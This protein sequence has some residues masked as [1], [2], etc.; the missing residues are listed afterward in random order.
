MEC[1]VNLPV[2]EGP[3]DLLLHLIK[4]Q[5]L[6]IYDIPIAEVT[7]GYLEYLDM[8]K[9]LNLEIAGDY[10]VMAAE[11]ARIK[12]RMLLPVEETGDGEGEED[13]PDPRAELMEK[14]I[15]Y[16]R[17]KEAACELREMEARQ[18]EVFTRRAGG[19][20]LDEGEEELLDV[21]IF[22]L[23]GAFRRVLKSISGDVSYE[24]TYEVMSVTDKMNYIT[25]RLEETPELSFNSLFP[26]AAGRMEIVTTFLALLE[27][28]RL[29]LLRALQLRRT[30]SIRIFRVPAAVHG[31]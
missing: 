1:K 12:S 13:A 2:F 6:D 23:L 7:R 26:E 19:P 31:A 17:Y 4:E 11:L 21:T 28:M 8:M 30:S 10:M 9:N 14:L 24:I 29:G 27:L 16:R 22:D 25:S 3:L 15:E 20:E 5:R 18:R